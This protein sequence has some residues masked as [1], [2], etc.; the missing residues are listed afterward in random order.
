L[1]SNRA[2][3]PQLLSEYAVRTAFID[4]NSA[5]LN[6]REMPVPAELYSAT[7]SGIA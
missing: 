7:A 5:F 6:L 3:R 1:S 4:P 2:L